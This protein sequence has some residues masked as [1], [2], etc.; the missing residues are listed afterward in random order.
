[1]TVLPISENMPL[2]ASMGSGIP[3]IS[4]KNKNEM[5]REVVH[6]I[7]FNREKVNAHTKGTTGNTMME[8]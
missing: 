3:V 4:Q 6:A 8:K 5:S 1:M 7:G 2:H